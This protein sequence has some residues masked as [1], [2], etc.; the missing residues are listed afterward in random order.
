MED[1]VRIISY[2]NAQNYGAVLQAYGL[3]QVIKSLGFGDV[4]FINYNP[5]YLKNRYLVFP[6]NWYKPR[7]WS[8]KNAID[9]YSSMPF[10]VASRVIRN[11]AFNKSRARLLSQTEQQYRCLD[12]FVDVPCDYL[13]LGSDQI[14]STWIT[15]GPD[16][17]FYGKGGYKGLKKRISYAPSSEL[18]TFNNPDYI[19]IIGEYLS[20]IDC[21]S[22][23]EKTVSKLLEE[24]LGISSEVCVDPTILS[25]RIHF[26]KI[27]SDRKIKKDYILV[28]AYNNY[29]DFIQSLIKTVPGFEKYEIHYIS[30]GSSGGLKTLLG[31]KCHNESSV[32]EFVSLFKY[33]SYVV[34]NSFHGLAFSLLFNRKF[35]IAYEEGKSSRCESLLQQIDASDKMVHQ[36]SEVNWEKINFDHINERLEAI[37]EE[38]R[39]FLINSLKN[40]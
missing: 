21:I 20:N 14:W 12:D 33:A 19:K 23:R 27:A 2:Q 8:F 25:G 4:L 37:R 34:T 3:Q 1:K 30:F 35:I 7:V 28:Y 24:K 22:V 36:T 16:P 29:S 10:R 6:E 11:N 15:G 13:V 9:F 39:Q 5:D 40:V 31:R 26:D 38:S 32:E 18:S 17:V